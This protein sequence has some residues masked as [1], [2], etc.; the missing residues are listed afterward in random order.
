MGLS[1]PLDIEDSKLNTLHH[2]YFRK[3]KP[4]TRRCTAAALFMHSSQNYRWPNSVT[5]KVVATELQIGIMFCFFRKNKNYPRYQNLQDQDIRAGRNSSNISPAPVFC[6]P[7][8]SCHWNPSREP[9]ALLPFPTDTCVSYSASDQTISTLE[10]HVLVL[11]NGALN[12]NTWEILDPNLSL[13]FFFFFI[14][15]SSGSWTQG[16]LSDICLCCKS[17]PF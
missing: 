10:I 13:S 4:E 9:A 14:F 16:S 8:P 3:Y 17:Q 5:V 1:E 2:Q 15:S 6:T 12:R 11:E 7:V